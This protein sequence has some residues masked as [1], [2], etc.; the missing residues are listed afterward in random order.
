MMNVH[1]QNQSNNKSSISTAIDPS[2]ERAKEDLQLS[3]FNNK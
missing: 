3:L 2:Y 1:N